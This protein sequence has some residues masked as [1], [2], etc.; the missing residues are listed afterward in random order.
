MTKVSIYAFILPTS[1]IY[2]HII[3]SNEIFYFYLTN[4]DKKITQI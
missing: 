1:K 4:L 3:F 2:L